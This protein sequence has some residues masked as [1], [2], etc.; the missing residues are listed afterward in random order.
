MAEPTLKKLINEIWQGLY[1]VPNTDDKGVYGD[2]KEIKAEI[3]QQNGKV[4]KLTR[5]FWILIGFLVGSGILAGGIVGI[6]N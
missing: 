4:R 2:I 1:G 5:N 6:V 3:K